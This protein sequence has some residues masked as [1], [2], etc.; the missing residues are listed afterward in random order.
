MI[1]LAISGVLA[2]TMLVPFA[3]AVGLVR[4]YPPAGIG[5]AALIIIP[6]WEVPNPPALFT[7]AGL[8]VAPVDVITLVL[9]VVGLLEFPQLQAN[10]QGWLIPWLFLGVLI[11]I[12]LLRGAAAFGLGAATNE[13]RAELWVYFAMTWAFATRPDRLRLHSISLFLGW[14]LV[15]VAAYHGLRF[16][17]GGP[18]ARVSFGDAGYRAGRVLVSSQ[19]AALLLCAGTVMFARTSDSGKGRP[20]FVWSSLAFLGVVLISQHRSVWTAGA[21]GMIAVLLSA[22]GRRASSRAFVLLAVGAS[23]AFVSW[24]LRTELFDSTLNSE[25]LEWRTIS[26]QE[27]VSEAIARGP[28]TVATGEPFGSG[29]LRRV[30]GGTLTGVQAHNWYVELFLR[31]GIIGLMVILWMLISTVLKSRARSSEWMFVLVAVGAYASAYA[32]DWFLAQWLAVAMVVSL[33]GGG[34]PHEAPESVPSDL[35]AVGPVSAR[36]ASARVATRSMRP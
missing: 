6:L 30:G 1:E 26:W 25:T 13:A 15:F 31:L 35:P 24:T 5:L 14:A 16:G 27:L 18:G 9:F 23:L 2:L 29:F 3:L 36:V 34:V 32:L 28:L 22:K 21:L 8:S 19:A 11:A 4:R 12:S 20:L 10:L 33:R 17:I 7:F